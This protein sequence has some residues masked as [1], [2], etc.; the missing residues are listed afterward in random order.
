MKVKKIFT[1][2][3]TLVMGAV[4]SVSAAA[5][6]TVKT[7]VEQTAKDEV[8]HNKLIKIMDN[9]NDLEER[10]DLIN[11][12]V[13]NMNKDAVEEALTDVTVEEFYTE[14][15]C[16]DIIP[17]L[18][19]QA[20]EG[21]DMKPITQLFID[22]FKHPD[23][24]LVSHSFGMGPASFIRMTLLDYWAENESVF[25]DKNHETVTTF[26]SFLIDNGADIND[27]FQTYGLIK[28]TV[29]KAIE[30]NGS[31]SAKELIKR[32]SKQQKK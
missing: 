31:D 28:T 14:R 25:I 13:Q 6:N 18:L 2:A 19:N 8:F 26:A 32:A 21:N 10:C 29:K 27:E 1:L 16:M 17:L 12:Y 15:H 5:K 11:W 7:E 24:L 9:T 22:K 4:L 20:A 23:N 3:L 30:K